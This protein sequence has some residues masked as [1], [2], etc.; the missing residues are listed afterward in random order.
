[1]KGPARW[2]CALGCAWLLACGEPEPLSACNVAEQTCQEQ[3]YYAVLRLRGDGWD[4][5]RG[6]PPIRT[7]TLEQY[8]ADLLG[9]R[10]VP[11]P[12]RAPTVVGIATGR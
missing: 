3:V 12:G 2:V 7:I 6:L 10:R 9:S 11:D 8:R 1:M 5:F 4:P